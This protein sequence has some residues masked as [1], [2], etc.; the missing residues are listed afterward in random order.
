[1][2]SKTFNWGIIGPGRIAHKFAEATS[3]IDNCEI[4]AVASRDVK[5]GEE[6]SKQYNAEKT[7]S[8][9]GGRDRPQPARPRAGH[10]CTRGRRG[11]PELRR[12]V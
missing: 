9:C 8:S 10:R 3:V 7:Y 5:K 6:F 12:G 1:M 11:A 2:N 4:Y